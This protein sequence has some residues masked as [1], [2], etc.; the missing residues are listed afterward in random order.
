MERYASCPH[1]KA[2]GCSHC[3]D[4]GFS[5]D[6]MTYLSQQRKQEP[7]EYDKSRVWHASTLGYD[8]RVERVERAFY[9]RITSTPAL[10]AA[11]RAVQDKQIGIK[12]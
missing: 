6:A 10:E 12:L 5:S 7:E 1:C 3:D 9:A 8:R 4:T 2:H 11:V